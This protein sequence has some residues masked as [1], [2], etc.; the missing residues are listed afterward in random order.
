M[1]EPE[2]RLISC[3]SSVFPGLG[4]EEIRQASAETLHAWDSIAHF[5]LLTVVA[6][7]FALDLQADDFAELTSFPLVL[8]RV[9]R[10]LT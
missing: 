5:T 3:F 1:S 4:E 10:A 7:E 6:E 2:R 8:E 9:E